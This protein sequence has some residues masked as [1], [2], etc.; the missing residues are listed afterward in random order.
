MFDQPCGDATSVF[1]ELTPVPV[2]RRT[3]SELCHDLLRTFSSLA[4]L[5]GARGKRAVRRYRDAEYNYVEAVVPG[6]EGIEADI[7]IHDGRVFVRVAR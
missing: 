2:P 5:R 4:P 6:L 7:C 3:I 1:G